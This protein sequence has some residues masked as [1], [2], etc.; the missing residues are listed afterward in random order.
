MSANYIRGIPLK[1]KLVIVISLFFCFPFLLL[2]MIW[3]T[4]AGDSMERNA[5]E[6]NLL[7]IGQINDRLDDYFF[8]LEKNNLS[9]L[10]HPLILKFLSLDGRD[11]YELYAT[12]NQISQQL[13]PGITYGRTD[14]HNFS[15]FTANR[16]IVSSSEGPNNEARFTELMRNIKDTENFKIVEANWLDSIPILTVAR[17]ILDSSSRITLG[18]FFIDLKIYET[19]AFFKNIKLGESGFIWI[20]DSN[21]KTIY[22]PNKQNFG[23][24]VSAGLFE[25]FLNNKQGF[26]IDKS[27]GVK[28]MVIYDHSPVTNWYLVSEVPVRELTGNLLH[29]RNITI[30]ISL[31]LILLALIL[32]GG[33]SL[34][35]TNPLLQLQKLMKRAEIGDLNIIAPEHKYYV[36]IHSLSRGFNQM[37][38]E[39]QRL[40]G[41]VHT[42]QLNEKEAQIRQR[43]T[44]IQVMQSQINPHFLHNTLEII[45]SYAVVKGVRPISEMA[46]ALSDLF[47]YS[48]NNVRTL[49]SLDEEIAHIKTYLVIQHT[50]FESLRVTFDIRD[51]YLLKQVRCIRLTLQPI[52]ENAFI[53]GYEEAELEPESITISGWIEGDHY[54]IS[55]ADKGIGM[56]QEIRDRF[57][58]Y[59]AR[60]TEKQLIDEDAG[61]FQ[62]VGIWNVHKRLR[63]TFGEPFGL[64]I[65]EA[66]IQGTEIIITLP[67][68][69]DRP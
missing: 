2:G 18:M 68:E 29:L 33:F 67:I 41:V 11:A 32:L 39:L 21:G 51:A 44:L 62:G 60:H 28:K 22:H 47:R 31:L 14:I 27:S 35:I 25:Q 52:I 55:I 54:K 50:R 53:H 43:D 24:Q 13:F 61:L 56:A 8:D 38:Q 9:M 34:T 45:N 12:S 30:F 59:F 7:L 3:N 65:S 46:T 23:Q 66:D 57:N 6:S 37:V 1:V 26:F 69:S 40:I 48:V 64:F 10:T 63:L 58:Q 19:S 17:R 49:V 4:I 16:L 36:E 42:A 15:V 5:A 20:A